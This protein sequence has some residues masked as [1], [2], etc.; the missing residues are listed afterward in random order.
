MHVRVFNAEGFIKTPGRTMKGD[1]GNAESYV[2]VRLSKI[3][4]KEAITASGRTRRR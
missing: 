2:S 3:A 4:G 1:A